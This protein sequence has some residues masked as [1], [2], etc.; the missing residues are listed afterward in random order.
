MPR[1]C[2]WWRGIDRLLGDAAHRAHDR[3]PVVL[4]D[5]R[6]HITI[7]P[8]RIF[9]GL[10][11]RF[12]LSNPPRP[13][14]DARGAHPVSPQ[15]RFVLARDPALRC[16]QSTSCAWTIAFSCVEHVAT[17]EAARAHPQAPTALWAAASLHRVAG[18]FLRRIAQPRAEPGAELLFA[19]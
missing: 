4:C 12:L 11:R 14:F 16:P 3:E 15:R 13:D 7:A 2:S 8:S 5:I 10:P 18:R 1:C 17:R 19:P 6:G 9:V